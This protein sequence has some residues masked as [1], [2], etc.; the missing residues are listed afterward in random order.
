LRNA[1]LAA[2]LGTM[3][4]FGLAFVREVVDSSGKRRGK[5]E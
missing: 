3:F 5:T 2:A 1:I 4:G